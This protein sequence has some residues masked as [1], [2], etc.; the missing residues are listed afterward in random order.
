MIRVNYQLGW[1][2]VIGDGNICVQ[3]WTQ[4]LLN[5]SQALP[6]FNVPLISH[7]QT[8]GFNPISKELVLIYPEGLRG[9]TYIW[10]GVRHDGMVSLTLYMSFFTAWVFPLALFRDLHSKEHRRK[11]DEISQYQLSNGFF[12]FKTLK[13]STFY[14]CTEI[15]HS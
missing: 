5:G 1:I 9:S 15:I 14:D 3:I 7:C 10:V 2:W 6:L 13:Q 11:D 12:C 8:V 4:R